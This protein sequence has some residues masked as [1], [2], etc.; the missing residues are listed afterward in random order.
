MTAEVTM[1]ELLTW[2]RVETAIARE[3]ERLCRAGCDGDCR[4]CGAR[5]DGAWRRDAIRSLHAQ[6][7]ARDVTTLLKTRSRVQIGSAVND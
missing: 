5:H 7:R 3:A 4:A 1:A 6:S 2:R